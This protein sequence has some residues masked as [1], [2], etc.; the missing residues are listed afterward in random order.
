MVLFCPQTGKMLN[1][2]EGIERKRWYG[3]K[4]QCP[5]FAPRPPQVPLGQ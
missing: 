5:E 1:E 2:L 3:G 4:L